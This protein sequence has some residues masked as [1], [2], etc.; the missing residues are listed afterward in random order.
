[1]RL[2]NW[3]AVRE[4]ILPICAK[5][6][7]FVMEFTTWIPV[8]LG[9]MANCGVVTAVTSDERSSTDRALELSLVMLFDSRF[10]TEI[11]EPSKL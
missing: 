5:L 10:F 2:S 7:A 8:L 6:T 11:S 4:V 3:L 9:R 1:M